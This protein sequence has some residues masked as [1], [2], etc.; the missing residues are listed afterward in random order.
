MIPS[1]R[2]IRSVALM[3]SLVSI[4]AALA[5]AEI[6]ELESPAG[7]G[8]LAPS[9]AP[10]G[11]NRLV[12]TWLEPVE[13]G[14]ALKFSVLDESGFGAAETISQGEGWFA[15]WA[16]TPGL[17]VLPGGDW[18]AHWLVKSGSSTYAYDVV[19][20]RSTDRGLSWSE[21]VSPHDDGTQ[22]EHGF[23]SY[24]AA[25]ADR[26]GVVWLDGR[27]TGMAESGDGGEG[28]DG[29]GGGGAMTLRTAELDGSGLEKTDEHLLDARVC[30]CCQTA[31]VV[32]ADGPVVVYRGRSMD[33]IRDHYVVRQTADGWS[34]PERLHAD[35]W[36]IG[37]CPVNGPAMV[38]DG[39]RVAVAWFTMPDGQP[40]VRVAISANS[41]R[42][43][44]PVDVLGEGTALGRVDLA[45]SGS[46]FVLS[47]VDQADRSGVLRLAGYDWQGQQQWMERIDGLNAGRA[48]GFP[49]LGIGQGCRPVVAWTGTNDG[50]R[51]V[52]V[53][54]LSAR[55]GCPETP[56][57]PGSS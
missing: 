38:A 31:S 35:N 11:D 48:S 36:R 39:E 12:L 9:F 4:S 26:V 21:P 28:H 18:V 57:A 49:R 8:S 37:G 29:H 3:L 52:R 7:P 47:W 55:A 33:E 22:T 23:V 20:A 5:A 45:L 1:P 32:S 43:F 17:F 25:S 51:R 42:I 40:A 19:M 53:A 14:H 50:E 16:D 41:G 56:K 6:E 10:L 54:R 13:N 30:D 2:T 15:N 27:N 44:E 34:E 24:Y 46:G